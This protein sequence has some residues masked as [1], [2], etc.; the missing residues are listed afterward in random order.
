MSTATSLAVAAVARH[1][2]PSETLA[3]L[4]A[5][6]RDRFYRFLEKLPERYEAVDPEVFKRVP[7]PI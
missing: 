1:D 4:R 3:G 6:L 7:V 2:R 5:Q